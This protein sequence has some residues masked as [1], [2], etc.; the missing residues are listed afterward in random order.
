MNSGLTVSSA[1]TVNM[2]AILL[3]IMCMQNAEKVFSDFPDSIMDIVR[4]TDPST[5]TQH[6]LY[7]RDLGH[8]QYSPTSAPPSTPK[9]G[10]PA[11]PM[12][13][14]SDVAHDG[15]FLESQE[16]KDEAWGRGC[17]TLLGDAAHATIP[18]GQCLPEKC[19]RQ[20]CAHAAWFLPLACL[21]LHLRMMLT[22]ADMMHIATCSVKICCIC[23]ARIC[24]AGN[25]SLLVYC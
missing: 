12:S 20:C 5:V 4:S 15:S 25:D 8:N 17:I 21:H 9:Q 16:G 11:K 7:M 2:Q 19:C 6:G 14:S 18:N 23:H 22:F 13:K 24:F 1:E 3:V 10:P